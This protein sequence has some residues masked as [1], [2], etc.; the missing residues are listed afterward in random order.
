MLQEVFDVEAEVIQHPV[1]HVP[2][3]LPY[4]VRGQTFA[5]D[6]KEV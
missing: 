3:C 4:G 6:M 5:K 1:L 2:V